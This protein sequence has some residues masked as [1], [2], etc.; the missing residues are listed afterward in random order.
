MP[1]PVVTLIGTP[2]SHFVQTVILTCEEKGIGYQLRVEGH[3]TPAALQSLTHRKIHPFGKIPALECDGGVLFE[4]SAICRYLDRL[5]PDPVLVPQTPFSAARMEQWISIVGSYLHRTCISNLV[6][7]YVFP[8]GPDGGVNR[9]AVTA[10]TPEVEVSLVHLSALLEQQPHDWLTGEHLSLA[11]LFLAPL[12]WQLRQTP[13]GAAL[14]QP[15]HS[16]LSVCERVTARR[17]FA[18]VAALHCRYL[19]SGHCLVLEC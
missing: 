2:I 4:T 10:S 8:R 5:Q 9:A 15:H 13:E 1:R 6:S 19:P 11:E 7:H 12:I 17:S 16:L 3:D 18:T 14:L